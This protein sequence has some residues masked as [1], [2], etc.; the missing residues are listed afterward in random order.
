MSGRGLMSCREAVEKLWAYIDG[1]LSENEAGQVHDHLEAC[2]ACYPHYDFQRAFRAFV[3]AH[4]NRPVPPGL[5][6][7]VFLALL[8]EENAGAAGGGPESR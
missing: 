5:R 7:R 8:A 3:A 4:T 2:R 6:R 1:E